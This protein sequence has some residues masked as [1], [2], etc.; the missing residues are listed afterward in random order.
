MASVYPVTLG[1]TR[2]SVSRFLCEVSRYC[3]DRHSNFSSAPVSFSRLST[4]PE[5]QPYLRRG[6]SLQPFPQLNF[7]QITPCRVLY[8]ISRASAAV[9]YRFF[10]RRIDRSSV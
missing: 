8:D 1:L 4:I 2:N 9:L 7:V 10:R 3:R 5:S 6:Q